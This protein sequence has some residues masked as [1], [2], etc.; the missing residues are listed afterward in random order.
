MK[1]KSWWK[2]F[3]VGY[4]LAAITSLIVLA[5]IMLTQN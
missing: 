4:M 2:G 5:F 3:A 1:S